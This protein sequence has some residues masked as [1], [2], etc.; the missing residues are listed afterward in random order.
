MLKNIM[1]N[2]NTAKELAD[3]LNNLE[4]KSVIVDLKEQILELREENVSLKTKLQEKEKYDMHF[5]HNVYWNP[6]ENDGPYCSKCWDHDKKA[7]RLLKQNKDYYCPVCKEF[8]K[9]E[10]VSTPKVFVGGCL[11]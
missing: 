2:I 5:K 7:V 9:N 1:D 10:T 4:L 11:D 3:K 6:D 8:V